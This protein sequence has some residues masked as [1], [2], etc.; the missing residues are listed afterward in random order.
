MSSLLLGAVGMTISPA[1]LVK[2]FQ[3]GFEVVN[4]RSDAKAVINGIL[5]FGLEG[6]GGEA[7]LA[8]GAGGSLDATNRWGRRISWRHI[9]R[10]TD[11]ARI[12][13]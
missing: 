12:S 3:T 5:G 9:H 11:I 6:T 13:E 4:I 1:L 8:A 2:I 7:S 10:S